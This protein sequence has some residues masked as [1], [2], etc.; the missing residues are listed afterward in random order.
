[1]SPFYIHASPAHTLAPDTTFE[2]KLAIF[3]FLSLTYFVNM[4]ICSYVHFPANDII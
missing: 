2:R 4:M 3:A 1:M